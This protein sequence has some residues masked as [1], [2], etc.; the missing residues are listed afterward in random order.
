MMVTTVDPR[1]K[2]MRVGRKLSLA[3]AVCA[4]IFCFMNNSAAVCIEKEIGEMT[5]TESI[6]LMCCSPLLQLS[7]EASNLNAQ[8]TRLGWDTEGTRR[9]GI[10]LLKAPIELRMIKGEIMLNP[11]VNVETPDPG[12][13][14]YLL[15]LSGERRIEWEIGAH[16]DR[17]RMLLSSDENISKETDRVE[18][19]FPLEPA[20]AATCVIS[21]NWTTE[22]K[23]MVPA[24]LSAPDFGQLLMSHSGQSEVTGR[25]EGSR[26]EKWVTVTL[27]LPMSPGDGNARQGVSSCLEF[28]PVL[29]PKPARFV[30]DRQ[31]RA[32]RR[33]WFN[34]IQLSCGASGGSKDVI[35]VWANNVL[36]DPV[37]SVL[38]MLVD[39][40]LLAPELA[41]GVSMPP[42][43]RRAVEYW[44]DHKTNEDGLIA[45]TARGTAGREAASE[46][47]ED[48]T[49]NQNVMDSNP[50][51][52]IG[53][54]GYVKASGDVTWLEQRI[55]DLEFISGYMERRD[56]DGDG[57]IESKQS[58][59]SRSRPPRNPD[60]AW[61][62]Y[63]TGHKNAYVNTLAYRA[64]RGLA[65]LE[66]RLGRSEQGRRYQQKADQLKAAFLP[67]FYN[68]ETGWV[69]WW[70]SRD[71]VL[72]DIYSDVPT[73]FAINY[74]L[75]E[76]EKGRQM[77]E[78]YW[79]ALQETGFARFDLGTPVCLR[80]VPREEMEAYFD[81]QQFLNGGCCVSNTSYLLNALYMTGMTSQ[82]DLILGAMLKRQHNGAFSNGGGFQN[83]FVDRMGAGAE[84]FDWKGNPTG[85]EGHLV[86]CW[87]FLHSMLLREPAIREH[88]YG[89][90]F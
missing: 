44:I 47:E 87:A 56:I 1:L 22:G 67:A 72:H 41:P 26:S 23:F 36:S 10:N 21:S 74:G 29:L 5:P 14:R 88:V 3:A 38:Y 82:A 57:L 28:T 59:N 40:T 58:G 81:F 39:A 25:I 86:Y 69:A 19:V 66:N 37:S 32:A 7:L 15:S 63:T 16:P 30:D 2:Y 54:W 52:L 31:W 78:R 50:S 8:I 35:G 13:I 85:Y 27:E 64:W 4:G 6:R 55:E 34:L 71:G 84:V 17:L 48:P 60:C 65:E 83:G 12:T 51:V 80:P 9:A 77:L 79:R 33:G 24:I 62:C 68:P 42:I 18:L 49:L 76:K 73:S 89:N 90:C 53:A 11:R 20:I 43:L 45:Y 75:I 61:D 46:T 70:R